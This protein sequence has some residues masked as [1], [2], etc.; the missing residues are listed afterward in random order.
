M[1]IFGTGYRPLDH[2]PT[3]MVRRLWALTRL[4]FLRLFRTRWGTILFLVCQI[5]VI[6]N[7]VVLAIWA[8]FLDLGRPGMSEQLM[9]GAP[10]Y[11][12][13]AAEYYLA[14]ALDNGRAFVFVLVLTTLGSSRSIA[15]DRAAL[16][17]E[18]LWTRGVGPVGYFLAKWVG[19]F[20]L[21]GIGTI[22][23]PLVI[24]VLARSLAPDDT[25]DAT[26]AAFVPRVALALTFFTAV[27]TGLATALSAI[28]RSAN[29]ASIL[30]IVLVLGTSA[31][32]RVFARLFNGEH[33]LLAVSPWDTTKRVAQAIA[34]VTPRGDFPPSV[35]AIGVGAFALVLGVLAARRLKIAEAVA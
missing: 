26:T 16:A 13:A 25:F 14:P 33:S 29:F 31:V 18:I 20:M 10:E 19:S 15:R 34:G 11:Y 8:G 32:T 22:A 28:T 12:P 6:V 2:R 35:A 23:L 27:L 17:L 4:E 1:T 21:I 7:L 24:W 9:R 30:W 5:P 3:P